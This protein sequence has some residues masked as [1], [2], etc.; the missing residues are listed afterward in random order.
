MIMLRRVPAAL[1]VLALVVCAD[2]NEP[3][4]HPGLTPPIQAA[5]K[6]PEPG[7][8]WAGV[9]KVDITSPN[10]FPVND[11]LYVKALV[12]KTDTTT[13]VI[14]TVDAVAI[15]EIGYIPND[16]LGKVRARLEK[17]LNL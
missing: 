5:E 14:A 2:T 16:F 15:G 8:L 7:Q 17:E 10:F 1:L 12:L 4:R 11:P 13:A 3:A 9:A 6:A